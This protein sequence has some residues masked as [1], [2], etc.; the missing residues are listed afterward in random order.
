MQFRPGEPYRAALSR[1]AIFFRVANFLKQEMRASCIGIGI[2]A[3]TIRARKDGKKKQATHLKRSWTNGLTYRITSGQRS[4]PYLSSGF[5]PF[6]FLSPVF[7]SIA[8]P[9]GSAFSP[10]AKPRDTRASQF[11]E[12]FNTET[13]TRDTPKLMDRRKG[14]HNGR[15]N[16]DSTTA[17]TTDKRFLAISAS[18]V[19][20]GR[21][22]PRSKALHLSWI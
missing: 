18:I 9:L 5:S 6:F 1:G 8:I 4:S 16:R 7:P 19:A 3:S 17:L 11:I 22:R 2:T 10:P 21:L 15:T 20:K 13:S 14:T 12:L